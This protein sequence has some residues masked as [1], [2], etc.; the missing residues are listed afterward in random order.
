MLECLNIVIPSSGLPAEKTVL[1]LDRVTAGH[2]GDD[3]PIL[4]DVSLTLVGP[5]RV[6]VMGPNGSGKSTLLALASG[7]MSPQSGA[8]R[9]PVPCALLDQELSLLDP[10]TSVAANFQRLNPRVDDNTAR[11]ALARFLFRGAAAM[12]IVETLS[13]GEVLRAAL[14]CVL[15]AGQPP[16]FLILDEPTNHLD[17]DTLSV[18]EDGLRSYDGA[19]LVASHDERFLAA[20][21]IERRVMLKR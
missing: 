5:E 19:L 9:R 6:A 10:H 20:I 2:A 1:V 18:L 21:G 7:R 12:R 16:E 4:H 8:V 13:G 11:A 15:G 14:A 17:L 3:A